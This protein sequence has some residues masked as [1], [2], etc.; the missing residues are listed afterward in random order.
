M[1]ESELDEIIG[2]FIRSEAR[3]GVAYSSYAISTLATLMRWGPDTATLDEIIVET[4]PPQDIT[5]T[6]ARLML[7]AEI[8][9]ELKRKLPSEYQ[10]KGYRGVGY[11]LQANTPEG[12]AKLDELRRTPIHLAKSPATI[13][14]IADLNGHGRIGRNAANIFK[15]MVNAHEQMVS[16]NSLSEVTGG[17]EEARTARVHTQ[18]TRLRGL[19]NMNGFRYV[20]M[21]VSGRGYYL[22]IAET[23][24]SLEREYAV[25]FAPKQPSAAPNWVLK[26]RD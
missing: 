1:E 9:P 22:S 3:R 19:S 23:A 18:I 16:Y 2:K 7:G 13:Q 6:S 12:K 20:I 24:P 4:W 5:R 26:Q 15:S 25:L 14:R 11:A 17:N 10:I 8:I 21:N